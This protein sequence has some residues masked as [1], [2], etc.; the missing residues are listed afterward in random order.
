M[1]DKR[2]GSSTAARLPL[3][4]VME[5]DANRIAVAASNP[6]DAVAQVDAID[7]SGSLHRPAVYRE[8]HR[9]ALCQR[10]HFRTRLH[11]WTLFR[12]HEFPTSEIAARRRQ[13]D[14]DLQRKHVLAV[15]ILMETVVVV[16]AV[17]Q[18]QRR[19]SRLS[20]RVAAIEECRMVFGITNVDPERLVPAIRDAGTS[21][22]AARR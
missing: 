2:H 11:A 16:G 5:D 13:Q 18:D 21:S 22:H 19:R 3:L 14:R 7:A 20:R 8:D 10:H 1:R 15:Q 9:V 17:L 6:A 4:R 12:Q